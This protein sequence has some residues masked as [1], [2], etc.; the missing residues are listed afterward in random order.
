MLNETCQTQK[1]K[2]IFPHTFIPDTRVHAHTHTQCLYAW[3]DFYISYI[4]VYIL[5]I[6]FM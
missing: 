2:Y 5:L 4:F 1:D 3:P 6:Y